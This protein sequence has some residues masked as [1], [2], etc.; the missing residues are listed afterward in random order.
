VFTGSWVLLA[1][2]VPT[3]LG[4][5]LGGAATGRRKGP[6]TARAVG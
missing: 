5:F 1:G 2:L 4:A 6:A 3:V